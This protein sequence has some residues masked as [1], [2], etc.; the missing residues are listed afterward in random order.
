MVEVLTGDRLATEGYAEGTPDPSSDIVEMSS[1]KLTKF[2]K[3]KIRNDGP[4]L[5]RFQSKSTGLMISVKNEKPRVTTDGQKV[6]GITKTVRFRNKKGRGFCETNDVEEIHAIETSRGYGTEIWDFD[7]FGANSKEAQRKAV[8]AQVLSD[9]E[10]AERL[11][12]KAD[13]KDFVPPVPEDSE[14]TKP[15]KSKKNQKE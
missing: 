7:A 4:P 14:E 1:P 15:E 12:V 2:V 11:G 9:P 5:R 13:A 8:I 3:G 6:D 10:L